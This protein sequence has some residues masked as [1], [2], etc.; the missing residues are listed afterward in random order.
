MNFKSA[1]YTNHEKTSIT[2]VLDD[3]TQMSIPTAGGNRHYQAL[4]EWAAIEG[5]EIAPYVVPAI[6]RED[7]NAER[8]RRLKLPI[9]VTIGTETFKVDMK[10]DGR[11]NI[12]N[13]TMKGMMLKMVGDTTTVETFRD[14]D[15]VDHNLNADALMSLGVQVGAEITRLHHKANII[16]NGGNI[17]S[18]YAD[19]SRWV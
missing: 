14:A 10:G 1:Q 16:K 12:S 11:I 7:V 17:P 19:D 6:S 15:N 4:L 2:A 8:D 5:N 13:L 9:T 3:D 18:D